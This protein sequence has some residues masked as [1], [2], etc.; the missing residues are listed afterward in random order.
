M[1]TKNLISTAMHNLRL[2]M[3]ESALTAGLLSMS[4]MTPFFQS[5]GLNQLQIS[6]TQII[7]TIIMIGLNLPLGWVAD[8][9]SRK[10][11]N[12]IGDFGT[13]L[14]FAGYAFANDFLSVVICESLLGCFMSLSQGVDQSLLKHF[15]K[16]IDPSEDYFRQ[17]TAY[18]NCLH[19]ISTLILVWLGGPI[20]AISF[21][22]A[23]LLSGIPYLIGGI[24]S[25][26]I[27]DNS[28]KLITRSNPLYDMLQIVQSSFTNR[29]LR[30]R[31]FAFAIGRE[32]THV[33]I[34]VFTPMMLAAGVPL[35]LV[36]VGW[37][38]NAITCLIGSRIAAKYL[39]KFKEWQ[40]F[41]IPLGIMVISMSLLGWRLNIFTIG[42]Y[43][44]MGI[45]Q[46]WTGATLM[47]LVQR[48]A[49]ADRQTS[50]IS[51]AQTVARLVYIPATWLVGWAA[52]IRLQFAPLA[53]VCI[54]LPFGLMILYG[55]RKE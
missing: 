24:A 37:A 46:G 54:F 43:L 12:I 16:K 40:I 52:D 5:I 15:C 9:F 49:S 25:C 30:L 33:I 2:V 41:A 17:K 6:Q 26:F 14:T 21:R 32:M 7:F 36:S 34:W 18:L 55:L 39:L 48:Y 1:K 8:R 53:T 51:L 19:Y 27:T 22:L 4:I 11:A 47:P 13:A 45:V 38:L 44:L 3:F 29:P 20:G 31:I 42:V 10:W 35:V 50:V 23:I 28:E